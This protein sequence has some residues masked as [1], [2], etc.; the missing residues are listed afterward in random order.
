PATNAV[1]ALIPVGKGPGGVAATNGTVWVSNEFTASLSQIDP[2][3][4]QVGKTIEVGNAPQAL[5]AAGSSLWVSARGAPTSHRGGTIT[6]AVTADVLPRSLDPTLG[7]NT[8]GYELTALTNDGLV[9]FR[10][11]GGA[12][13]STV[14]PDLATSIPVPTDGGLTYTFQLRS[15]IRYSDG[16]GVKAVDV[17]R[18]VERLFALGGGTA[19]FLTDIVGAESCAIPKRPCDLSR[20]IEANNST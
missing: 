7:F 3:T 8:G 12:A 18:G 2:G 17:R 19:T 20:G 6:V 1:T 10:H 5:A 4:N 14:V 11:V 15:G 9:A 13:G 16:Q